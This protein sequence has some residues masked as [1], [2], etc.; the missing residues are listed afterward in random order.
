MTAHGE[1]KPNARRVISRIWVL[2]C[3]D[4]GVGEPVGDRGLDHSALLGDPSGELDERLEAAAS[5]P[6]QP[7]L[8]QREGLVGGDAVDL[9]ELFVEQVGAVERLVGLLDPGE[10]GLLA[11]GEVLGVLPE[12]E[13][14]A[15]ELARELRL[16]FAARLVPDLAAD[17]VER[18]GRELD[19][20]ERV[21]AEL[22]FGQRSATGPVIQAAM[23][24]DTSLIC[25]QRSSPSRSRNASVVLRSRPGRAH[26]SRPVSWSTTTVRYLCPLRWQ[27]SSIPIRASPASRSRCGGL[28]GDPLADPADRPPRDPHQLRDRRLG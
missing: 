9:A 4:A 3:F 17:L 16:A 24:Q 20:V 2:T 8:E 23:S 28:V 27:I 1:W 13:P 15:L 22:A 10:L 25:L 19:D 7:G 5:G 12:R 11:V 21:E 6:A 14:G 18:L 26:T